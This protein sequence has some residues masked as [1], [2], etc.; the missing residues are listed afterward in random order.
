MRLRLFFSLTVI[1]LLGACGAVSDR[2]SSFMGGEDNA[3]P[4]T[5]LEEISEQIKIKRLWETSVGDGT[6]EQYLKLVPTF[7]D[8]RIYAA[9]SEGEVS[10]INS[11]NGKDI[12]T[13]D[14]DMR[15]TGGP[16]AGGNFVLV[17]TSEAEVI[18]LS[19]ENGDI[20]WR[21]KVSS[22]VLSAPQIDNGIV[23]VRTIDGKIF[24]LNAADGS[25]QWVY[26]RTVP[27]LTLRGTS[28]PVIA[29]GLVIAGFDEGRL[30][31]IE[32][33]TGKLVWETRIALATGRSDI[34]RMVDI[35]AEPVILDGIIYVATFQG[36]LA[37]LTA[38]SG[39]IIWTRDIPSYAGINVD[40]DH[41]YIS[42]DNSA[43]W[44][45][46]RTTG[47]SLW[48]LESLVARAATAPA[49]TGDVVVVGDLEGYL[50]WLDRDTGEILG[51]NQVTDSPIIAPPFAV[52]G[53]VYTYASDGSLGAYN[54]QDNPDYIAPAATEEKEEKTDGDTG[55]EAAK[56]DENV[57]ED[58]SLLKK[59]LGGFGDD[60][61]NNTGEDGSDIEK[62][63]DTGS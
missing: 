55:P 20:L 30:A 15:I 60:K 9:E 6:D 8:G 17:G 3:S 50:H 4:P 39:R 59:L 37:A 23:V 24:G 19:A 33:Q 54:Y 51:R 41:V 42:D 11:G 13:T 44:A 26:D 18:A 25:R 1:L 36:R 5:P 49:L 21:G 12:W 63:E 14:V 53:I 40:D 46:D 22:E 2:V 31:A 52:D 28:R 56:P 48:K 47:N 16:G 29:D 35:D 34:E 45:L 32:L 38:N 10:A 61:D 43:I 58:K 7:A 57:E 62:S 27:A